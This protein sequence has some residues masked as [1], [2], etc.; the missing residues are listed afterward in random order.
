M[1][2]CDFFVNIFCSILTMVMHNRN[3]HPRTYQAFGFQGI[4]PV[5]RTL[6]VVL[7]IG[8]GVRDL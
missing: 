5:L 7:L 1:L 4:D 3:I 6:A 2:E 8:L